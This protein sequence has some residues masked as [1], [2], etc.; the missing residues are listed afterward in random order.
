MR[1][2]T[3]AGVCMILALGILIGIRFFGIR[4]PFGLWVFFVF[5]VLVPLLMIPLKPL[6]KRLLSWRKERGRDIEEEQR[7]E[8]DGAGII[9]LQ[10]KSPA[11]I[12][13]DANRYRHSMFR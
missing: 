8:R 2:R 10:P 6:N 9:S 11:E 5:L 4:V 7:Y 1:N 12:E 13:E 3:L